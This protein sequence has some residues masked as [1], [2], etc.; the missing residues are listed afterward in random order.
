MAYS[1]LFIALKQGCDGYA[2]DIR[3]A[4]GRCIIESRNGVGRLL[5]QVQG[6]KN[7]YDYRVC[8]LS[9]NDCAEVTAH[10]Y[11]D[12]SGRG[13]MKWEFIPEA[14][15]MPV[16]EIKACV[17]LSGDKSP[18]IGFTDGEYNWQK[19]LMAKEEVKAAEVTEA[20]AEPPK[21]EEVS[22]I[23]PEKE[24]LI[25]I[26]NELDEDIQE[27]KEYS[28]IG[29]ESNIEALFGKSSVKPFGDDGI[30]WVKGSIKELSLIRQLWHYINNPFVIK[31]CRDYR[32]LLLGR[33]KEGNYFLGVPCKY[34]SDYRLEAMVQGF[35]E[36]KTEDN[37]AL[38]N[39]EFCY[40]IL[41]C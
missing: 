12:S 14:I 28:R 8:I 13:E 29:Y 6:I 27:M 32:H 22:V 9:E 35:T 34:D 11:I 33:D 20:R 1:R 7:E 41:K 31:G 26:I 19:C 36:F 30:T 39:G 37:R 16:S 24:K 38:K 21:E 40:C 2:K 5:L 25:C 4:V 23:Y 18:L 15:G 17:V 10:L 3:G